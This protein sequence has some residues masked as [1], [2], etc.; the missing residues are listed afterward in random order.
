MNKTPPEVA[1]GH[2]Q[3]P[4]RLAP[5]TMI[6][7]AIAIGVCAGYLDVG[8]LVFKKYCVNAEGHFRN[9]RDFP[10]T[11]PVGHAVLMIVPGALIAAL[12]RFWPMTFSL[13]ASSWLLATLAICSAL[14]RLPMYG[15]CSLLLAAGLGRVI[16]DLVAARRW[17]PRLTGS[18]AAAIIGVLGV[19]AL[20]SSGWQAFREHR[21]VAGLPSPAANARNVVLIVWDTVRAYNLSLYGYSRRT[22]P[23][24]EQWARKGVIYRYALAPA[25]WTFPSHST[26]FTGQWPLKINSQWKFALDAPDPTLAEYLTT[27]GYQTAGFVANTKCCSYDT[28]LDRG[29]AHFDDYA[30]SPSSF[31]TRT[32]PGMWILDRI[33]SFGKFYDLKWATIQSRDAREINKSFLGWLDRRRPHRP[34]FAFLNYFDAHEPYIPPPGYHARFG[35]SPRSQQDYQFLIDYV[36]LVKQGIPTEKRKMARDCYDDC[37]GFLDE[38]T[39]NLLHILET[40]GLL[41]NTDVIITSDHGESF[42]AHGFAGHSYSATLEEVGVPL[43]ILSPV[44]PAE[45]VVQ[46]PVSLRD[47]P[48]TVVDLLGLSAGSPFPGR[49]LATYWKLAPGERPSEVTSPAFS[50]QASA[51]AFEDQP[52]QGREHPGF[53]MSLVTDDHHYIRDGMGTEQL[54]NL[55]IDRFEFAN[56][57]GSSQSVG[58]LAAFRKKLLDVLTDN[59]GS[60]EVEKAYLT[61]YRQWLEELVRANSP[62]S[63]AVSH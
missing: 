30:L 15:W 14:L 20:L 53:Q 16:G 41:A 12:N 40:R 44:A 21:I 50:E 32:V 4:G 23:Y 56:L 47:L 37:I 6:L 31:L 58:R 43:V 42:F 22:T 35:I 28:G 34:F 52:A 25:P 8:I 54:Y 24:L 13:R 7:L 62:P 45:R 61:S 36:G 38:Q 59:P 19:S 18:I 46:S 1:K 27:Q 55:A 39:G 17:R 2:P 29:F 49:S 5:I 26:F 57:A 3:R 10:W 11:V 60:S 51:I 9:A 33:L 63:V 48:A